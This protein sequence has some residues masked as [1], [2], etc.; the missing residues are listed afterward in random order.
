MT[1]DPTPH[2]LGPQFSGRWHRGLQ[3]SAAAALTVA[4]IWW[5]AFPVSGGGGG[6][7]ITLIVAITT[8]T[9]SVAQLALV[10]TVARRPDALTAAD[11]A[12]HQLTGVI[13][14][15]PWAVLMI[16]ATLV[17]E[18]LHRSRP[19]HTVVLAVALTGCLLAVH[20]AETDAHASTLRAQL[21][22]LSSGIGLAAL[23]IGA[24]ALPG[25]AVGPVATLI[26]I[27]AVVLA[28]VA[29]GLA[30]P[31]WLGRSGGG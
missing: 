30:V 7:R 31:V 9:M 3:L 13:T 2:Q 19:W 17:L 25:L 16:V 29:A 14:M 24:A 10:G 22:L 23:S 4:A 28:A 21:P 26:R 1:S 20:L 15:L 12:A 18:A 27:A 11:R 5:A 8:G 6:T